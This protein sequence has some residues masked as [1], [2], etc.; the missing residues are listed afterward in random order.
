MEEELKTIRAAL[1]KIERNERSEKMKFSQAD[2]GRFELPILVCD[3]VDYLQP[4]LLPNEAAVYWYLFKNSIVKNLNNNIRFYVMDLCKDFEVIS[5]GSGRAKFLGYR[6]AITAIEGLEAKDVICRTI[7]NTTR[8]GYE[9]SVMIPSEIPICIER[10][11]VKDK[12]GKR[13]G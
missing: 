11:K 5:S 13:V 10:K 6:A 4:L 1:D 12:E 9:Y 2:F 7:K 3:I 8:N